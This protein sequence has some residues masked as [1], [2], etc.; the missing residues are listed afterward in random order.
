VPDDRQGHGPDRKGLGAT[1]GIQGRP[2]EF[3]AER[4]R[5]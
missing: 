5:S 4:I 3:S 2:A 1:D